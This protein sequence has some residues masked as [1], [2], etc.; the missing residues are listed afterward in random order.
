M[1]QDFLEECASFPNGAH[2]DQAD[3]MTQVLLRWHQPVEETSVVRWTDI[4]VRTS[5]IR[6]ILRLGA[7]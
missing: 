6:G 7:D 4:L 5:A 3:A 2:D 1:I